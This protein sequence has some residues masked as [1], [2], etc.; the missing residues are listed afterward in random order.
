MEFIMEVLV[1][2]LWY[3]QLV[4]AGQTYTT[5][6]IN[7]MVNDNQQAIESIQS[8][9]DLQ[10]QILDDF[11]N[12]FEGTNSGLCEPWEEEEYDPKPIWA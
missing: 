3:L 6:Q 11:N 8:D 10:N 9:E 2:I 7:T 5:D 12:E 4:F 1:A